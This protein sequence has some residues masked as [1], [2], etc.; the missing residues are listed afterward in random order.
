MANTTTMRVSIA[1][2]RDRFGVPNVAAPPMA[3][4]AVGMKAPAAA[5]PGAVRVGASGGGGSASAVPTAN[6]LLNA[7]AFDTCRGHC[8]PGRRAR[9]DG[10]A[11]AARPDGVGSRRS[12]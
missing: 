3:F 1:E 7:L 9:T 8:P 6:I 12:V 2:L 11:A 5:A 10:P 4:P